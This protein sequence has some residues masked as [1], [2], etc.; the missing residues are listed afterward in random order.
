MFSAIDILY[1]MHPPLHIKQHPHCSSQIQALLDCHSGNPLLKFT[2]I[3]NDAKTHLD[4]CF[5]SEKLLKLAANKT[6]VAR[7]KAAF[8]S[9][10]ASK[11]REK[12]EK[13]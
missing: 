10:K 11:Q 13:A 5:K 4:L 7:E 8:L 3:C 2:G 9:I 1:C 12:D 6:K